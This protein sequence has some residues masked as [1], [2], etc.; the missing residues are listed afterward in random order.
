MCFKPDRRTRP[1]GFFAHHPPALLDYPLCQPAPETLH[2]VHYVATWLEGLYLVNRFLHSF[3]AATLHKRLLAHHADYDALH[4]NLFEPVFTSALGLAL[5]G[6]DVSGLTLCEAER[7]K[8]YMLF[9]PAKGRPT[10]H[11]DALLKKAVD[12]SCTALR[13]WD[14]ATRRTL[15]A[16]AGA[17]LPRLTAGSR[18][19]FALLLPTL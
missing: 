12:R 2:G 10:P 11:Y 19:V 15:A 4:I 14:S 5:A 16:W 1:S 9:H 17:L 18:Q 13:L 6:G 3:P 8:L 7:E